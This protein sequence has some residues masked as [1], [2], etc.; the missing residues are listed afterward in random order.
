[1][2]NIEITI[3]ILEDF[4]SNNKENDLTVCIQRIKELNNPDS[5]NKQGG[6]ALMVASRHGYTTLSGA[7]RCR[8]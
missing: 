4:C 3:Q 2:K 5:I 1:M 6:T 7:Y 8:C